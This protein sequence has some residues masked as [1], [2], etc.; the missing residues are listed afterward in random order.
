MSNM[1]TGNVKLDVHHIVSRVKG[2][3]HEPENL[4]TLC[5][6]CHGKMERKDEKEQY[7]L[8]KRA[9]PGDYPLEFGLSASEIHSLKGDEELKLD[10]VEKIARD[11]AIGGKKRQVDTVKNWF[12]S[13]DQGRAEDLIRELIRD[14]NAP[15]VAYGG[16]ARDNVQLT[17][18]PNA[19]QWL[20]DHGRDL[21]WL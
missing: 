19:K 13:S 8:L 15:V 21:W 10:I 1:F 12:A 4:V 14:A 9:E 6:G 16:G 20:K 2:G 18:I 5:V 17:S 7:R 3:S 11:K